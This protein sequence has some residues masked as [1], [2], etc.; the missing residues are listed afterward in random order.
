M[1]SSLRL[2]QTLLTY[3]STL[4]LLSRQ[5]LNNSFLEKTYN[6]L[7]KLKQII[8]NKITRKKVKTICDC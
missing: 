7:G 1:T 6:I 8:V 3:H 2:I 4:F 5:I